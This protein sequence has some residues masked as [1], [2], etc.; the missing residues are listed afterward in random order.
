MFSL[1]QINKKDIMGIQ[2]FEELIVWQ[3]AQDYSVL[4]YDNFKNNRDFSF[5]D[6]IKRASVSISN[7]IAEGFDR[8]TNPD[9]K[10][11]LYISLA[12]NSETRSMLYLAVRLNF[13]SDEVS[14]DLIEKSNEIA[15]MLFGLIKSLK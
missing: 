10:R 2:K 12:S 4:I 3:K 5:C 1:Q 15:K 9:F 6:Q 7:N 13:I 14:K 11:F 8:R